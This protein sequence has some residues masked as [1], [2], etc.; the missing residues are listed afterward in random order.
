MMPPIYIALNRSNLKQTSK[1][2]CTWCLEITVT[3]RQ[4]AFYTRRFEK[5]SKTSHL[6]INLL[7]VTSIPHKWWNKQNNSAKTTEST[8]MQNFNKCT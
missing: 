4:F 6:C 8:F 1:T 7:Q 3:K 5:N 2:P